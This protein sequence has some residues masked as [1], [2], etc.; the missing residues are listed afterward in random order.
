MPRTSFRSPQAGT[1]NVATCYSVLING[2]PTVIPS[3]K[4]GD[5]GFG[6]SSGGIRTCVT[7]LRLCRVFLAS[8]NDQFTDK[9]T[10][11]KN[12]LL[13]QVN[14]L[15]SAKIPMSQPALS[16]TSYAFGWARVQLPGRMGDIACN[17]PL[18]PN[19]MPIIGKGA[20]SQL[21]IYHHGSLPGALAASAIVVLTNT[22]GLNDA[23]DWVAHLVL[24][25]MLEVPDK[26]D[27]VAAARTSVAENAKWYSRTSGELFRNRK[28]NTYPRKLEDYT[29]IYWDA[30]HVVKIETS[31]ED[32]ALHWALQGSLP[33]FTP[34]SSPDLDALLSTF[35]TN[36]F[37]PSQLLSL[38]KSLVYKA[39]NHRL[40]T[41]PE[42]P[43]TVKIGNEVHQLHPLNRF[44]DEPDTRKSLAQIMDLM[45]EGRDWVNMIPFLEGLR[46]SGRKVR[47]WQMEKIVRRMGM[48]GRQ[49]VVMEMLR[50][51][52]GTGVRWG[53]RG[54]CREVFWGG[55]S[56]CVQDGWSEEGVDEAKK[57]VEGW[58][59]LLSEER[60]VNKADRKSGDD[61]RLKPE[62]VG[63]LLWVRAVRSVLFGGKED[64]EG[65]V[66]RAAEMVLGVWKDADLAV[67]KED[68]NDA[69]HKLMMWAPVWHGMKLAQQVLGENTPLGRDLEKAITI[70]LEPTLTTAREVLSLNTG[71]GARRRGLDLYEELSKNPS[72]SD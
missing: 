4:A 60:H 21:M 32:G 13:K 44:T 12:S 33:T 27:Y 58:W 9:R 3:V 38:Q 62:I 17:P 25:E 20:P 72:G 64:E 53:E 59:A 31:L 16:E 28:H 65:K 19:G 14:H 39:K 57:L 37:L 55:V 61:P 29:G 52:E 11:T 7:D 22:L 51:V 50:Q 5:D 56:K 34:T 67:D 45:K 35:R 47:G 23:A 71:D 26:N 49:G 2:T 18:M 54:V 15:M 41:N 24:E 1:D 10:S 40:L 63:V 6:A 48:A 36:I 70:D 69:N 46:L 8:A 30:I 68:W 42:E 66:K 43:A